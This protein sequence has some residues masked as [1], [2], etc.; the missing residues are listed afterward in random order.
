MGVSVEDHRVVD[1]IDGL[2]RSGAQ[3]KF[4]SCE[5]LIGPLPELDLQGIDWVI[6]SPTRH[7]ALATARVARAG[8]NPG[9]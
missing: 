9:R 6:V 8:E 7:S 3:V 4:L 1:R 5:P 2:R